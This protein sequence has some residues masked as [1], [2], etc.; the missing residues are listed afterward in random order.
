MGHIRNRDPHDMPALVFGIGIGMSIDRIIMIARIRGVNRHKRQI[1]Q[2]RARPKAR[3]FVPIGITQDILRKGI[4]N[5]VLMDRNQ[6][7]H[8]G[9]RWIAQPLKHTGPRQAHPLRRAHLFGT[10]QF[11]IARFVIGA[12]GHHPFTIRLF[13]DGNDPPPFGGGAINAQNLIR[14]RRNTP[15]ESADVVVIFARLFAQLG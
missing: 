8:F 11:A 2:I 15:N 10:H 1:P 3:R 4:W 13:I 12:R 14:L 6:R 9:R 7:Y 5:P